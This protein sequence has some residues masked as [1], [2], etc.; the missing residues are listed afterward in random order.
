MQQCISL[1]LFL[2]PMKALISPAKT[3]DFESDLQ[4]GQSSSPKFLEQ[5][6]AVM[7]VLKKKSPKQL[8]NLQGISKN[9]AEQNFERNQSWEA[10]KIRSGRQAALAFKGDV[11]LGMEADKWSASDM[12]FAQSHLLILSGLYGILR[13]QDVILPYRLEMGTSLSV[14]RKG[15]LYKFWKTPLHEYFEQ[16]IQQDETLVNL[17]SNE[18][19]KAVQ[20]A[21]AKQRVINITFK[22]LSKGKYRVLAFFAKKAR[23]RMANYMVQN[24]IDTVN[25]LKDFNLDNY[26][27][28]PE[29]STAEEL[30][31]LRDTQ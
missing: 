8:Q 17:A 25:Q 6:Q 3:L 15:N 11:Y 22:D 20:T 21:G 13:P 27:F 16:E 18:Y 26:Y 23:G 30:V 1:F 12:E 31:F 24:R 4:L 14:A 29:T 10:E 28:D 7:E 19:F 5:A 2:P 9:L